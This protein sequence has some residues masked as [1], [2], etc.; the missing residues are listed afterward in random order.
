MEFI[1]KIV[2]LFR[3]TGWKW[4][5]SREESHLPRFRIDV[6]EFDQMS[7]IFYVSY[8]QQS[9][10]FVIHKHTCMLG[11]CHYIDAQRARHQRGVTGRICILQLDIRMNIRCL[12][13]NVSVVAESQNRRLSL[14]WVMY[15]ESYHVGLRHDSFPVQQLLPA[16]LIHCRLFWL[17]QVELGGTNQLPLLSVENKWNRTLWIFGLFVAVFTLY[18]TRTKPWLQIQRNM[19]RRDLRAPWHPYESP[20]SVTSRTAWRKA[21]SRFPS[22][23]PSVVRWRTSPPPSADAASHR[24][25]LWIIRPVRQ[26]RPAAGGR[27]QQRGWND[28]HEHRGQLSTFS[29][30]VGQLWFNKK[31]S[32]RPWISFVVPNKDQ[33]AAEN[34]KSHL[35]SL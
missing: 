15:R 5:E 10:Y 33:A 16:V 19:A 32:W 29:Q 17:C 6:S 31:N 18:W 9:A 35:K 21:D 25:S 26:Q 24:L 4:R 12:F 23:C 14:W 34:I 11:R 20:W 3:R 7:K 13:F 27:L 30:K 28:S 2:I 1:L 8:K 22:S